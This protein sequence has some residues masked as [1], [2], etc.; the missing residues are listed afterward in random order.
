[1]NH[2]V[3]M[4]KSVK[5]NYVK[6]YIGYSSNVS[7]RLALHNSNKGAK[8]TKGRFWRLIYKKKFNTKFQAMKYEY[9]LKKNKRLRNFIKNNYEKKDFDF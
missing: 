8:S 5:N 3:Y 7:R 4:L 1:M 9:F 2:F 6:T